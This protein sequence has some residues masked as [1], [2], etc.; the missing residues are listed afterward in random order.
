MAPKKGHLV[1]LK[2]LKGAAHLNGS[3]G[4]LVEDLEEEKR[5]AV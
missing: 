3:F 4:S 1:E 5:W 2:G